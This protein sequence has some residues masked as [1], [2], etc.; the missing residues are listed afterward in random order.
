MF[1]SKACCKFRSDLQQIYTHFFFCTPSLFSLSPSQMQS[2][3]PPLGATGVGSDGYEM[4]SHWMR[5]SASVWTHQL[6]RRRQCSRRSWVCTSLPHLPNL[7]HHCH[8]VFSVTRIPFFSVSPQWEKLWAVMSPGCFFFYKNTTY[9]RGHQVHFLMMS[10]YRFSF[11][12]LF[13]T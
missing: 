7:R 2:L 13:R 12:P 5:I 6:G 3:L 10:A 1:T 4:S 11:N 9:S 8:P